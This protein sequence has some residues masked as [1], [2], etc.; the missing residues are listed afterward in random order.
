MAL[1]YAPVRVDLAISASR[2]AFEP[3]VDKR[4]KHAWVRLL[5]LSRAMKLSLLGT[6]CSGVTPVCGIEN[7]RDGGLLGPVGVYGFG[8]CF[9]SRVASAYEEVVRFRVRGVGNLFCILPSQ[10]MDT[11]IMDGLYL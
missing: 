1:S 5:R 7:G 2:R 11:L 9:P 3:I 10:P 6:V 4:D 8:Q